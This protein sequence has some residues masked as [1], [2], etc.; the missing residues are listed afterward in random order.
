M[1]Y[2]LFQFLSLALVLCACNQ[3]KSTNE[4]SSRISPKVVTDTLPHDSDDPAF[5]IHP[6]DLSKSLVIG[7]DKEADGGI[8]AF[9]LDGKV[10]GQITPV[11]R[12]NNVDVEYGL[13]VGDTTMDIAVFTE[14]F[15]EMIRVVSLP[16][17]KYIDG[18][19]I[20]VFEGEGSEEF[21]APMGITMYKDPASG[22]IS[23]IVGRKNGPTDGTYL[24]QYELTADTSGVVVGSLK[25][26]FGEYSGNGE[27]EALM[28]DDE[29]GVVYC[30][31]EAFGIRKY[32]AHPDS[33]SKEILSFGRTEFQEDR[34]GI[35]L[36]PKGEEGRIVISDQQEH[37]FEV[38]G[39]NEVNGTHPHLG[40][41]YLSTEE[42]DGCDIYADSLSPAFPKG[43][44][45]A[46]SEGGVFHF[47]DLRDLE[48]AL[49][50]KN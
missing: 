7:N 8:Y 1:R 5:W 43:M 41:L 21:R 39:R 13:N 40:T 18:G 27:I 29:N 38:F 26:K 11:Q 42:T 25:R 49:A 46:M 10:V 48:K 34:E 2:F 45:A 47:Y 35:A 3:P 30:S 23:A 12:P 16:D 14:R 37:T 28:S 19:G 6:T 4:T 44:M 15:R 9:D 32:W 22:I 31:D 50:P 24:W 36:W 33:T 20:P 17:L